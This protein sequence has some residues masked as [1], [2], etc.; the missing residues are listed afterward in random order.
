[1]PFQYR[2]FFNL[3]PADSKYEY[4]LSKAKPHEKLGNR[5]K[6]IA[7]YRLAFKLY[8][9]QQ[10]AL[11]LRAIDFFERQYSASPLKAELA[12]LKASTLVQLSRL[13][14]TPV[15]MNQALDLY[16][17]IVLEA[18]D[19]KRGRAALAFLVQEFIEKGTPIDSLEYALRGAEQPLLE[20]EDRKAFDL[21]RSVF[22]LAS[23][24]A[25]FAVG[26][27]DRA[28]RA[29]Q[30][31]IDQSNEFSSEA[32]FRIGEVYMAR[33]FWERAALSFEQ[34]VR[35][36]EN[37]STRFPTAWL[38]L[39]EIYFQLGKYEEA[40]RVY[41]EFEK[42]FSSDGVSWAADL[43]L[44][45]L[46]QILL[47]K[48][49]RGQHERIGK[50]YEEVIH[51]NPYSPG[52]VM[53]ELRLSNC[54][55]GL[56]KKDRNFIF[57]SKFFEERNLKPIESPLVDPLEVERWMDLAEAR[58]NVENG[59]YQQALKKV[60]E[61][62]PK[63][64]GMPLSDSFK[65]VFAKAVVNRVLELDAPGKHE[66][67]L[68]VVKDYGDF[69]PQPAQVSY[70]LAI[71]KAQLEAK[72]F[73]GVSEKLAG[74]HNSIET[75][76]DDEKDS[77]WYL[78]GRHSRFTGENASHTIAQLTYIR[79]D[80]KLAA[81]KYDELAQAA[82]AK[83]DLRAAVSYDNRILETGLVKKFPVDRQFA[84]T[85]RRLENV[86]RLRNAR[87]AVKLA[88]YALFKFGAQ[89]HLSSSISRVKELYAQN[90]YDSSNFSGAVGA[91]DDLLRFKPD[92]P[93]R[94]E[95]E[96]MRGK[97]LA[98]LGRDNE[99]IAAFRKLAQTANNDI[100]KKS[101]QAELDQHE[102]ETDISKRMNEK[103]RRSNQ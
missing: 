102:W 33:K 4:P 27:L 86:N 73:K 59:N 54:H 66:D 9:E 71:A 43:R 77:Y 31:V 64:E 47:K 10:Y 37:D 21:A 38:N 94:G 36:R 89:T 87:E 39:A 68:A 70:M 63:L 45:E 20:G 15:Y 3:M 8:N 96:F 16:R 82:L 48:S 92:H 60:G 51:R 88:E 93:R 19:S 95:F 29:Y 56:T 5:E 44:A 12:F 85:L 76:T 101:A 17:R 6:E 97:S 69:A 58:F 35:E 46:E 103:D 55:R 61:Y 49:D 28:E 72:D 32:V 1:K 2:S 62:R 67:L 40:R 30:N 23:A 7:H 80:G 100:W 65:K 83:E 99:A 98:S 11:V 26:E 91:I 90:L 41:K 84:I 79:D 50:L 78:K 34:A 24:E 25:L 53:A 13:L 57:F 42:R 18:P 22:R 75:A 74:L 52:A 14:R 81:E